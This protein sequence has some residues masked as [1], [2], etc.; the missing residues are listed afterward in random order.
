M[1]MKY[2]AAYLMC[3]LG[4]NENPGKKEIKN[5]L[6][7][8]N[9]E[10]EEEVLGNLLDSLKGKSYHELISE[11]LKKLQNVGGGAAAA[12]AAPVAGDTGD[13]KKEEKKEEKEEEEE[14]E[15]DLGFSL[16]G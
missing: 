16:F 4:G 7:A 12:A 1:A 13:S 6:S 15:D 2:V 8:V 3:V 5:V 10:V 9:A 14:E 11:G